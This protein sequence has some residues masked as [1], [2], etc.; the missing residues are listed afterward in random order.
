MASGEAARFFCTVAD[1]VAVLDFTML[2]STAIITHFGREVTH[3][4]REGRNEHVCQQVHAG[5]CR[6]VIVEKGRHFPALKS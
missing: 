5:I 4:G 1:A 6:Q 2:Y 3:F